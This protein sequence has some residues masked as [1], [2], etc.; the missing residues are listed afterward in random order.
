MKKDKKLIIFGTG[1]T[2]ILAK[3]YFQ[4]DSEYEVVAFTAD[5]KFVKEKSKLN[6]PVVPLSHLVKKYPPEQYSLFCGLAYRKLNSTREEKY[7][8]LKKF[9]Y[10]MASYIS[11]RS[12][13]WGDLKVGDNCFILENQ[14]IQP[15]VSIGNNVTLWSGNH[16]GHRTT[17]GDH[18][19]ITSHVCISG[20]C[21]IG[22]RSFIGVNSA[23]ADFCEIGEDSFLTVNSSITTHIPSGSV[24]AGKKSQIFS[25]DD[26]RAAFIKKKY[27]T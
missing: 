7:N 12:V 16:I 3:Y 2:G 26:R 8:F 18:V 13:T 22:K 15:T 5:D 9:G 6:L 1:E 10:K 11:T 20:F 17:I 21:K 14:T 27:F 25:K 24:V 19:Y 23:I 4:N